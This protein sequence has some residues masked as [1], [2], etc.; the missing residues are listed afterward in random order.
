M[1]VTSIRQP[2]G[3]CCRPDAGFCGDGKRALPREEDSVNWRQKLI[4]EPAA[5]NIIRKPLN[6]RN[7]AT[8]LI[9]ASLT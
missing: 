7:T 9:T 6:W 1:A 3:V 5:L 2:L 4:H 8:H